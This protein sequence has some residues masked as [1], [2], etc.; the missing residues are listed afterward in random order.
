M[1]TMMKTMMTI[2]VALA[3][4]FAV[5]GDL[6]AQRGAR[7]G[8]DGVGDRQ[9]L[10]VERLMAIAEELDLT[11]AQLDELDALRQAQLALRQERSNERLRIRS[12]SAA[13]QLDRADVRERMQ[14]GRAEARANAESVQEQLE[15]ILSIDQREE[16]LELRTQSMRHRRGMRSR[17]PRGQGMRGRGM[18]GPWDG[19]GD[20]GMRGRWY[21]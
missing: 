19:D 10:Q 21:R 12:E 1:K 15:G 11:E 2:G 16:L 20:R 14:E 8:P 9:G 4:T 7:G 17:G 18:R 5:A 3:A 6:A 13:G